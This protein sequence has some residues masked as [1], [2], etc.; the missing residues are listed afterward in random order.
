MKVNATIERFGYPKTLIKEYQHWMVLL[1]PVQVTVGSLVLACKE[2]AQSFGEISSGAST[3]LQS[4][5]ADLERAL[6]TAFNYQKINYLALMM[7]DKEVHFHVL[8]R[9]EQ[10]IQLNQTNFE[11]TAWPG[12]PDIKLSLPMTPEDIVSVRQLVADAWPS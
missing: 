4:V 10:K 1:R 2:N 9:Y 5:T 6:A 8:P 11:D 3:E 7:V 12:P